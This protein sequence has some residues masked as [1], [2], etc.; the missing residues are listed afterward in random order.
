LL[1]FFSSS[2]KQKVWQEAQKKIQSQYCNLQERGIL[3]IVASRGEFEQALPIIEKIKKRDAKSNIIVSFFSPS[4]YEPLKNHSLVD[5]VLYTPIDTQ[6]ATKEFVEQVNPKLVVF[7]KYELWLNLMKQLNIKKIPIFL[8]SSVFTERHFVGKFYGRPWRKELMKFKE[9][10]TQDA[11]SNKFLNRFNIPNSIAGDTRIDRSLELPLHSYNDS[12]IDHLEPKT[13]KLILGSVWSHDLELFI[14][15]KGW[16]A[17]NNIQLII[18]PHEI[19]KKTVDKLKQSF[20]AN[21][22]SEGLPYKSASNVI[23]NEMGIL[24]YL[25]RYGDIVYIGGGFGKGIHNTLEPASY[26]LPILFGPKH[27][28]FIEAKFLRDYGGAFAVNNSI[29]LKARLSQLL[30]KNQRDKVGLSAKQYLIDNKGASDLIMSNLNK[31][32]N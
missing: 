4:G 17:E 5:K 9:I 2:N 27:D 29:E 11:D 16:F 3:F 1:N 12:N 32:L 22:Y 30:D 6:E 15:L 8:I 14:Q 31:Y 10:F 7:V 24:K 13:I 26:G 23:V 21:I 25:Y 18:A 20:D 19:D 28:K